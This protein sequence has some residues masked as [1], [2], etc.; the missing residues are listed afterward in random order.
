MFENNPNGGRKDEET[1]FTS[2]LSDEERAEHNAQSGTGA[3]NNAPYGQPPY[4]NATNQN[5]YVQPPYGNTHQAQQR[6]NQQYEYS[7]GVR[8]AHVN[9]N[10]TSGNT[11]QSVPVYDGVVENAKQPLTKKKGFKVLVIV[12]ACLLVVGIIGGVIAVV[13]KNKGDDS[14]T[15]DIDNGNSPTLNISETP[16]G[17]D[18]TSADGTLTSTQ[19]AKKV[20]P[21]IVAVIAYANGNYQTEGTGILMSEDSS[22]TYTYIVTCAHII[23]SADSAKIQLKDETSYP[24]DI[25]GYDVKTDLAVLRIK[26]SGF[27]LAEFGDSEALQVG[28]RIYAIG[29]PGGT[30]FFGSF[31]GGFVSAIDRPITSSSI[32]YEM[33]CIQ[34]D[35]AINPGNSGGALVNVYGQV[36]GINSSKISGSSSS[37]S[38]SYEGMSFAIPIT[39]AKTY[40]DDIIANGYVTNRP[41]LG[42]SYVYAS[43]YQIYNY[44]IQ[45]GQI[46]EGSLVIKEISASSDLTGKGVEVGDVITAFNGSP[47]LTTSQLSEEIAKLSVG[48][49]VTLTIAR[50]DSKYNVQTF[51]VKVKLVEDKGSTETTTTTEQSTNIF[52]FG[53]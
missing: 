37:G 46:P 28:D 51:D 43:R 14:G 16:S 18:S 21:S 26:A 38:A 10:G 27:T 13:G 44:F 5:G 20:E 49:E 45:Q 3:S 33:K 50:Y 29:N 32:G 40:I 8:Y 52:S 39:S 23:S 19:I 6:Y 36:V 17:D 12:I 30:E 47:L 7:S 9:N 1:P 41:K 48:D 2:R 31:T 25:V 22:H 24:A 42:I 4:Q 11:Q 53:R 34:H 15:T 35:A